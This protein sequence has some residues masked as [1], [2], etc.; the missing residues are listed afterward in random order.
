MHFTP[1]LFIILTIQQPFIN[2]VTSLLAFL[3]LNEI[4][5]CFYTFLSD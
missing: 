3:T 1:R 4:F 2:G 5:V